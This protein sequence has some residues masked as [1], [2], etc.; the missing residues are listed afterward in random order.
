MP[1]EEMEMA[2][3]F[4]QAGFGEDIDIDLDFPAGEPD[5][6]MD[7]GDFDGVHD[8]HNFN[9]DTRDELMAEGDDASYGM[10]DAVVTDHGASAAGVNDIDID[11][12]HTAESIWQQVAGH[13]VDFNPDAEID[14]LDE[15][16]AE[17]MDA[18]RNDDETSEWLPAASNSQD[19]NSMSHANG[20]SAEIFTGT[21]EPH[22]GR[23]LE[24]PATSHGESSE[25]IK[26]SHTDA[27]TAHSPVASDLKETGK[28]DHADDL[29]ED[30]IAEVVAQVPDQPSTVDQHE[31]GISEPNADADADTENHT[32]DLQESNELQG[33]KHFDEAAQTG[34][35]HVNESSVSP[36][37][38][39][40]GP[41]EVTEPSNVKEDDADPSH[42]EEVVESADDTSE[43]QLGDESYDE[44]TN[45]QVR[46][47]GAPQDEPSAIDQPDSQ[48]PE[49]SPTQ[50]SE[51]YQN[52]VAVATGTDTSA[53]GASDRDDPIELAD[54]Y[55]IYISYG[56]TDYRLFA[57]SE[58]DD[59]N[60]YF[61]TDKSALDFSLTQFLTSLR[62]V[63]SEEVSPLDDLVMRVDGL[64]IE[65]S[66]ST[67][68]EFL[69][70]FTFGDLVVLYD[71]LVKNEEAESSPPI[72]TYLAV[73][74]NCIRRM[75]AL[76]E[77]ANVGRG[78]S[79][80]A[81]YRDSSS[82]D[83]EG[84]NDV[85]GPDTDFSN[86]DYNDGE[87]DSIYPQEEYEEAD[88]AN[89]YGQQSSPPAAV[90][91]QSERILD[92]DKETD[93]LGNDEDQNSMGSS[94]N[95]VDELD[96]SVSKQGISPLIF[97]CP[98]SCARTSTCS[99]EDCYEVE[100]QH[101]ATPIRAE[102]RLAPGI[103]MPTRYGPTHMT[104]MTNHTITEDHATSESSVLQPQEV[105]EHETQ[106]DPQTSEVNESKP[107][108]PKIASTNPPIDAPNSENTSV[109]ATLDGEEQDEIDYNSNQDDESHH[110]DVDGSNMQKQS[111]STTPDLNALV[112][113]EI[114]WESDDEE[115][116]NETKDGLAK[117][118]VQVS[119]V[120]LKRT[121]SELDALDGAGDKNDNKRR[122]S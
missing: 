88:T 113:D 70:K 50:E 107:Y 44:H 7:L 80:V 99:C 12:E 83:E 71:K 105:S 51:H 86:V 22:E 57:K 75:M 5:E 121:R 81:L 27:E 10:I 48:S 42:P 47:D 93:E 104:W 23:L 9:S 78:L 110:G 79:E 87:S 58:N 119:P 73:R 28:L 16:T 100:L 94:T 30:E 45:D 52:E 39:Q 26:A 102:V 37:P 120:S 17:N 97:Q 13:P 116:K 59:P 8:I 18:E 76:G 14:Y 114:T 61:L 96:V 89:D 82:M 112:D 6:D 38:K 108:T 117:D 72:Y 19:A 62:D 91:A 54:H 68:L 101:L 29:P 25:P 84:T 106:P 67:T 98:F 32:P 56:E 53:V 65:F 103:V 43:Y 69:E 55:G 4:G 92:Q 21:Q 118:A 31:Q 11:L 95:D 122:R 34:P 33:T 63:I 35:D 41:V 74:P 49:A 2:V 40:L 115:A 85:E 20:G 1:D 90:E 15:T 111:S 36:D 46:D 66:E 64:G 60:Q 109:T 24:E 3:D 77:S